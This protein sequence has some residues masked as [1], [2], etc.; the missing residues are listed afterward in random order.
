[1]LSSAKKFH[2]LDILIILLAI[3]FIFLTRVQSIDKVIYED[4]VIFTDYDSYYHARLIQ[5]TAHNFP[6]RIWF[7][8]YSL[9]PFGQPV[10]FGPLYD[11][12]AAFAAIVIGLGSPSVRLIEITAAIFPMLFA[13]LSVPLVYFI[14]RIAFSR[15]S[16]IVSVI[17]FSAMN[18]EF[19]SRS[20]FGNAD[21]HMAELF[22]SL[23]FVLFFIL[24]LKRRKI[25]YSLLAGLTLSSYFLVW[26]GAVIF[27]LIISIFLITVYFKNKKHY[28]NKFFYLKNIAVIMIF[29]LIFYLLFATG[30]SLYTIKKEYYLLSFIIPILI[31]LFVDQVRVDYKKDCKKIL[32]GG[33]GILIFLS[34]IFRFNV[35]NIIY[36]LKRSLIS[37]ETVS[38]MYSIFSLNNFSWHFY[39]LLSISIISLLLLLYNSSKNS[40]YSFIGIW[41]SIMLLL[42]IM[43][44][45]F[46]Y[47]LPANIALLMGYGATRFKIKKWLFAY[48]T[49][50][51]LILIPTAIVTY[52]NAKS[53]NPDLKE[54]YTA[55]EWMRNNTSEPGLDYYAYHKKAEII[56]DYVVYNN[57]LVCKEEKEI[58][59]K[60][61]CSSYRA[62]Q[63]I[64]Y[65]KK[66]KNKSCKLFIGYPF[67]RYYNYPESAY[68]IMNAY[69]YG[70]LVTYIARRIPITNG[71]LFYGGLNP[72]EKFFITQKENEAKEILNSFNAKYILIDY[73]SINAIQYMAARIDDKSNYLREIESAN[74]KKQ[75]IYMPSYYKAISTRLYLYNGREYTPKE[76]YVLINNGIR[77]FNSYKSASDYVKKHD[78]TAI[79]GINPYESPIPLEKVDNYQLVYESN[80]TIAKNSFGDVKKVKIFGYEK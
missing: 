68:S 3:S 74:N 13:M 34:V 57:S 22:F 53:F 70:H 71:F 9:Y 60:E 25:I 46:T 58:C 17:V 30:Y 39:L 43:Q 44:I 20:M 35:I 10:V 50:I 64:N 19:L 56:K 80:G 40:I 12:M 67:H 15:L 37:N 41:S 38:E 33:L 49:I 78:G 4:K 76:S 45:R 61:F 7:D 29:P 63:L 47:Y 65:N 52:N 36:S 75:N 27:C 62:Y 69:P 24:A 32:I 72:S 14:S 31:A 73:Y 55:L 2:K 1:M 51:V 6:H 8:P 11:I 77:K 79:V 28:V 59:L 54:I 48:I 18:W 21:H 16:A 42:S 23:L 5:N 26:Y 66:I